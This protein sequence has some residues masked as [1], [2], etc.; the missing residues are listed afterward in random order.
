MAKADWGSK[1]SC[2]GCGAKYYDLNRTPITCP[3]C[4]TVFNPDALLR[5]R[6]PRNAAVKEA[7]P[8][9]KAKAKAEKPEAEDA[10]DEELDAL[11]DDEEDG[12]EVIEDASELGEDDS[13]VVEVV[14]EDGEEDT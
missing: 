6:K 1:H 13:D 10:I 14:V 7:A 8:A 11:V 3:K 5:S 12:D 4:G 9:V 2:Q